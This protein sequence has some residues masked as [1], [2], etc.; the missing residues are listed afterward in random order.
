MSTRLNTLPEVEA[1]CWRALAAAPQQHGHAWRLMTLAT[2]ARAEDGEAWPDA[3]TVVLREVQA[4]QRQLVFYTDA[5]S[6]KAGQL[7]Q[8]PQGVLVLWSRELGWQLR[9]QVLLTLQTSGLAVSSRWAQVKLTPSAM[10]YLAP[11]PPGAPLQADATEGAPP[12]TH[13]APPRDSRHHFAVV[14]AQVQAMD[15]LELHPEGH[16]RAAFD[17]KGARW[18]AP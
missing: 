18:L 10:D 1:A 9:L 16:R 7:Q 13:P 2:V 6:A 5:R 8:Q 4:E 15:W 14:T 3:R 11:W 12:A 17:A